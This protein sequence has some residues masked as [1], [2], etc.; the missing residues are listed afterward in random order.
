MCSF[1]FGNQKCICFD[2]IASAMIEKHATRE[3]QDLIAVGRYNQRGE[4]IADWLY[5]A[6]ASS[7]PE[8]PSQP[9]LPAPS[10]PPAIEPVT[11][12]PDA[13]R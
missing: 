6:D 11:Q 8:L 5:L 3:Q 4:F 12:S 13:W 7:Q 10:A 1:N 2:N 9:S